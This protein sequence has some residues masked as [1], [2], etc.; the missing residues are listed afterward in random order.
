[1][2]C[3]DAASSRPF[4]LLRFRSF[5]EGNY[6]PLLE[7]RDFIRIDEDELM[8]ELVCR[9]D[10]CERACVFWSIRMSVRNAWGA[11]CMCS[12]AVS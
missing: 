9:A 5:F 6:Q 7:S 4:V 2:H 3:N 12:R 11:W 10:A 1:M 8:A